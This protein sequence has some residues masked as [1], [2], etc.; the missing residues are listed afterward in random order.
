[1]VWLYTLFLGWFIVQR[2]CAWSYEEHKA[3]LWTDLAASCLRLGGLWFC[4]EDGW[5]DLVLDG[6]VGQDAVVGFCRV[7][8]FVR[9]WPCRVGVWY[10]EQAVLD[11]IPD[12]EELLWCFRLRGKSSSLSNHPL[13]ENGLDDRIDLASSAFLSSVRRKVGLLASCSQS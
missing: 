2:L 4:W 1:M 9:W 10:V 11:R 8:W 7:A 6:V 3:S 12:D 5:M 13:L